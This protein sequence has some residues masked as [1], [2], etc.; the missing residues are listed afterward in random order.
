MDFF[1]KLAEARIREWMQRPESERAKSAPAGEAGTDAAPL[2]VQL[3]DEARA[4][5]EAARRSDDPDARR[6]LVERAASIETRIMVLLEESG[7]PL[8]AQQFAKMLADEREKP[9][10]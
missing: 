1:S 9:N 2:E 3:F 7:R 6:A 4:L 10:G 8:A 5:Y